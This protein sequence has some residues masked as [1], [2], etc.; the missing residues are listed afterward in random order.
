M[1]EEEKRALEVLRKLIKM[2]PDAP[3]TYLNFNSPFEM[4][5]AT[6]LSARATDA[7]VNKVTPVLFGKYPTPEKLAEANVDDVATIVRPLGAYN[8]KAAYITKTS[9]MILDNFGGEVPKTIEEIITFPGASRK[10]ANVVLQTAFDIAEGVIM[11]THIMRVSLRLGFTEHE[12]KPEK[13]EKDVMQLLP[14]DKWI[15][16]AR[17]IGT[18]G[19]RTCKSRNP[20]CSTCSISNLCP[21]S[22]LGN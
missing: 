10:T 9:R 15:N 20:M 6:I 2:Y 12:K 18:H 14:K 4:I 11:D 13:T 7:G 21:S 1:S 5:I 3:P 8:R 22:E 16:Y 17:F 19:R